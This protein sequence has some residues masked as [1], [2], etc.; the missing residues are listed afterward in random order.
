MGMLGTSWAYKKGR[1]HEEA[2]E[3]A[4]GLVLLVVDLLLVAA[5]E[6]ELLRSVRGWLKRDLSDTIMPGRAA[7]G[8]SYT[9]LESM[10]G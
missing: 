5:V 6:R 8:S 4:Q 1:L 3:P 7:E 2:L 10:C 9:Y